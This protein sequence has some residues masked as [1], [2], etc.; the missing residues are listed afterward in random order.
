M[1]Q[2]TDKNGYPHPEQISFPDIPVDLLPIFRGST[3]VGIPNQ[4]DSQKDRDDDLEESFEASA[5]RL[6]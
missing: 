1:T 5:Q 3:A 4:K 2:D 6:V